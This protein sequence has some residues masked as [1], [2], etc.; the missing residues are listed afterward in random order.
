MIKI[1]E[2]T[3]EDAE[4]ILEV[5]SNS[6][7]GLGHTH[8]TEEEID[9]WDHDRS[10][11]KY[12]ESIEDTS[13]HMLVAEENDKIVGFG[14]VDTQDEEV[15]AIYV[16]P[17]HARGGVG[18]ELLGRIEEIAVEHGLESLELV[19]SLNAVEFYKE[20]GYTSVEVS[21]HTFEGGTE[22]ECIRM[23]KELGQ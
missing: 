8:Y 3:K 21:S 2:A 19:A 13:S 7:R 4:E 10:P 23:R 17:E 15:T 6:I 5:H 9:A 18:S 16:S 12:H 22:I 14:S 1:R 20:E 11:E